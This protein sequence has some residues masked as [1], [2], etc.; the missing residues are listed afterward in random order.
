MSGRSLQV[1][2]RFP[3]HLEAAR[4]GKQLH[5]VADSVAV[6]LDELSA[7]MAAVRRSHRLA[8]ADLP[9]DLRRIAALHRIGD[10]EFAAVL[11]RIECIQSILLDITTAVDAA[12]DAAR[13]AAAAALFDQ[14]GVLGTPPRLN[15][16]APATTGTPDLAEAV[17]RLDAR[18]R[19][20]T[21]FAGRREVLRTRIRS[22]SSLH[23]RG[24]ATVRALIEGAA[25][26]LGLELD[27]ARNTAVK[28][29]YRPAVAVTQEG[30]P[31]ETSWSYVVVAR[32]RSKNVDRH[33]ATVTT[34]TGAATLDDIDCNVITWTVPADAHDFLVFR[35]ASGGTPAET[36]LITPAALAVTETTVRDTGLPVHGELE[37]EIDDA[38]FHSRDRFWHASFVRDPMRLIRR[39]DPIPDLTVS[40]AAEPTITT[41]AGLL[42]VDADTLRADAI[43]LDPSLEGATNGTKIPFAVAESLAN[44]AG[45]VALED[46]RIP[47]E[48][49]M[50]AVDLVSLLHCGVEDLRTRGA[51]HS[52][53]IAGEEQAL[54]EEDA[55]TLVAAFGKA[56]FPVRVLRHD[57]AMT[58]RALATATAQRADRIAALATAIGV[59]GATSTTI[60]GPEQAATIG[61]RFLVVIDHLLPVADEF[62]GIEENPL[63]REETPELEATN[64]QLF[65]IYRRG[66][67]RSLLQLRV[68]GIGDRTHGPMLVNRDEGRG[69]GFAG[70]VADGQLLVF[71]EQGRVT[72]DGT[73][74]TASAFAWQG[75]CFAGDDDDPAAP[76]DFVLDG[77]GA[78]ADRI[79]KFAVAEPFDALDGSFVF[80]HAG[81]PLTVPG[82][83]VGRTRFAFFVQVAHW[84]RLDET[85]DPAVLI[86]LSPRPHAG[87]LDQS[88]FAIGSGD[89][90]APAARITLSWLEHEAY[91][92]RVLLP[93]RFVLCDAEE[94]PTLAN[95]VQAALAR[96]RA[97][98]VDLR[99][100]YIEDRWILGSG[101]V[102]AA[103]AADPIL[104]LR[105][106]SVLWTTTP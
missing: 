37:P 30:T 5:V 66:F 23:S 39:V 63:R 101:E 26:A 69:I 67:D 44:A 106:G 19:S 3:V 54:S 34:T 70:K 76:R 52:I 27:I 102:G 105:G 49:G 103:D 72:L 17:R 90:D 80:P 24:N 74:V 84:S 99:V 7:R 91:A 32:S 100:E 92:V 85:V 29:T 104:G 68:T 12:D 47:I 98:G 36:G 31:G 48:R 2:A 35:V 20:L 11:R 22:L 33:S 41:L 25:S 89:S 42:G 56:A 57:G 81:D 16:F 79:A 46:W 4:P 82:V 77:P 75:A 51:A 55:R 10:V 97:A 50:R 53:T 28:A 21:G 59:A 61:R 86:P 6:T 1:L 58:V 45:V 9:A 60:L 88:V 93:R 62:L 96:H 73:D 65:P 15:L 87:F 64:A 18:V 40:L 95:R 78:P 8:H 14:L 83:G 94:Q 43:V 13:D 38:L 71:D